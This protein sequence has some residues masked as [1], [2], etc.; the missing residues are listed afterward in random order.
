MKANKITYWTT[1]AI[2][3]LAMI[4]SSYFY[5]SSPEVKQ[6]F[7]HLGYPDYFRVELAIA[8]A[9]GVLLLLQTFSPRIKEWAYAGF[10]ITFISA[11]IAHMASGD[12]ADKWIGPVIF[13]VLLAASYVT[14]HRWHSV[15][16]SPAS[17]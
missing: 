7:Q 1:T 11:L 15:S 14:Y 2:L 6:G 12:P 13:M 9:V 10:A 4:S 16:K 8:K 5:I 3:G 17:L